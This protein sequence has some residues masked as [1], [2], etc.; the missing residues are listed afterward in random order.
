[1]S[2]YCPSTQQIAMPDPAQICFQSIAG[3]KIKLRLNWIK[4]HYLSPT[5]ASKFTSILK[6]GK[7]HSQ[8]VMAKQ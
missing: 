1:M 6:A 7:N 3:H 2:T 4:L 8:P 5:S